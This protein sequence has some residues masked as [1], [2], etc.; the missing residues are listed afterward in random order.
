MP[1]NDKRRD[2]SWWFALPGVAMFAVPLA[3]HFLGVAFR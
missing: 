2:R 3:L 1:S